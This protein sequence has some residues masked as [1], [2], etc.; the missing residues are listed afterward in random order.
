MPN[1]T[2]KG[3][4]RNDNIDTI[5]QKLEGGNK[6]SSGAGQFHWKYPYELTSAESQHFILF[7][8]YAQGPASFETS[9][10]KQTKGRG[11]SIAD[12][13][14]SAF[15]GGGA[16]GFGGINNGGG[17]NEQIVSSSR[18]GAER[19]LQPQETIA[20]YMTPQVAYQQ[21]VEWEMT[22]TQK[23]GWGGWF[24]DMIAGLG[25]GLM[26][27]TEA[28]G[29]NNRLASNGEAKNPNKEALFKE[30]SERSFT[31]DF[32]FVPK[33]QEETEAVHMIIRIFRYHA[34]PKLQSRRYFDSPGE[35]ELKFFSGGKENP[36][37][38]KLRR[39]VCTS[40]DYKYGGS[41]VF[42]AFDD[43]APAEVSM[44]LSFQEVE[45]L[46]KEHITYG[47]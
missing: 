26:D 39:L 28:G 47:F 1:N 22:K 16:A 14:S 29:E 13:L 10:I 3:R 23:G 20:L 2:N 36:Y 12:T 5:F 38:P 33:S 25:Q 8:C 45:Q 11:G 44:S 37:M 41:E 15:G 30:M 32:T 40:V 17:S 35:F 34:S 27:F 46:H 9:L 43:G 24:G 4:L 19:D 18:V 42:R 21:K 6:P 7:T 31:F